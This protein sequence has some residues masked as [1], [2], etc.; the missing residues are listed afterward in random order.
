V[1]VTDGNSQRVGSVVGRRQRR[2][3]EHQLHHLLNLAFLGASVS[4]YRSLDFCRRVLDNRDA[5]LDGG[6]HGDTAGVSELQGAPDV[7]REEERLDRHAVGPILLQ[8]RGQPR[9]YAQELVGKGYQRGTG[10]RTAGHQVMPRT[11]TFNATVAGALGT[12]IDS[13]NLHASEASISFSEMS[14]FDQ[15]C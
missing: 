4:D 6:Q 15:T 10:D 5:C 3:T 12:R 14:K 2:K 13:K 1:Q 11:V 7:G 9:V 8:E